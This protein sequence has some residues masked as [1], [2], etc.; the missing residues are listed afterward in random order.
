MLN[1][2]ER[3]LTFCPAKFELASTVLIPIRPFFRTLIIQRGFLSLREFCLPLCEEGAGCPC[4]LNFPTFGWADALARGFCQR[5]SCGDLENL[6]GADK[7]RPSGH[8]ISGNG[9][10]PCIRHP[11]VQLTSRFGITSGKPGAQEGA[12]QAV[13]G[14]GACGVLDMGVEVCRRE[15][16][17]MLELPAGI[18]R[19]GRHASVPLAVVF[20]RE[21]NR[22]SPLSL[23]ALCACEKQQLFSKAGRSQDADGGPQCEQRP[24]RSL[25][26]RVE[27]KR[28]SIGIE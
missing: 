19:G 5:R 20:V 12:G 27:G 17:Q 14:H 26:N 13:A 15:N 3:P 28:A 8:S 24:C 18:F 21:K 2:M 23:T 1:C 11:K 22:E 7:R 25:G 10:L 9:T 4:G 6:P 16:Q